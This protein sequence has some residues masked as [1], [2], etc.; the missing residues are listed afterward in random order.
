MRQ[1]QVKYAILSIGGIAESGVFMDYHLEEAEF[2]R[3]V[4]GQAKQTIVAADH[5]KFG[6]PSF[7]RVCDFESVDLVVS[8]QPPPSGFQLGFDEANVKVIHAGANAPV[9]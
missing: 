6:N 7:T 9:S 8:D 3:A 4:I 1:F 2:S 5:S